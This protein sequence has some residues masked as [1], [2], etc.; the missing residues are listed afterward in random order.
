[1]TQDPDPVDHGF[2]ASLARPGGNITELSTLSP[3]IS[4]KRLELLND[5]VPKLS[6]VAVLGD[7]NKSGNAQALKEVELAAGAFGLQLQYLEVRGAK[8]I[9]PAFRAATKGRADALLVLQ[10]PVFVTERTQLADLAVKS[11]LRRYTGGLI[12]CKPGAYELRS[13]LAR[14]GPPRGY[15]CRQDPKRPQA[16]RASCRAAD[17][18]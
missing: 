12:L 6:R 15:V 10:S 7:S 18:I 5:I 3:E 16:R 11:R 4:G 8:N 13:E 9:E 2:V 1:M 14:L 17:E